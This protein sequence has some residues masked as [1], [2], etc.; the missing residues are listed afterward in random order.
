MR[1]NCRAGRALEYTE[2]L[3]WY[4]VIKESKTET[5]QLG[6]Q[7]PSQPLSSSQTKC[8]SHTVTPWTSA[9][10]DAKLVHSGQELKTPARNFPETKMIL[11]RA[12][13]RRVQHNLEP[14]PPSVSRALCCPHTTAS[15]F[16]PLT[17]APRLS[18]GFFGGVRINQTLCKG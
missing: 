10:L 9:C 6:L 18:M 11:V 12:S 13:I 8:Q 2:G 1:V 7:Q 17:C 16:L 14:P 5:C 4:L 15:M 3:L